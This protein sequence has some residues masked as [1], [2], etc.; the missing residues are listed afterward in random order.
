MLRARSPGRSGSAMWMYD[1]TGGW[2]I[3]KLHKRLEGRRRL[4]ATCRRCRATGWRRRTSTTTPPPTTPGSCSPS[5]AP[6]PHTAPSSPTAAGSSAFTKDDDGQV[7]R[8]HRRRRRPAR[9]TSAPRSSSTP[10]AC[11]PTTCARSTRARTP[12]RSAR[13]RASTSPCRGRR[14][15]TTSPSSSRCRRTSAACSSCRGASDA[16]GTFQHTYVGTTDTDYDGPL[17]DPQCT[18][19]DIAYVLGR[20]TPRHHRRSPPTTSPACGPGCARSSS[21]RTSGRTADLSRRHRVDASARPAS[22]A[23]AG[24]KLTTYREMAEDTVDVVLDRLGRKAALPHQAA[25]RCSAPTATSSRPTGTPAAHLAGRFGT[26]AAA[27]SRRSSPPTRRSASRSSPGLPYLRAEAVY[28]VRH[29]MATTLDDVLTRRTRAHLFDRPATLAAAP[30]VAALI[31]RRARLGRRRGRPPGRRRTDALVRR[32]A[33]PTR[34]AADGRS[35]DDGTD[36]AD[37]ADRHRR[38]RWPGARRRAR[39]TVRDRAGRDL[40]GRR[41]RPQ[42]VAE[43]QPRLVAAGAALGAGRRGARARRASSCGPTSTDQVAAVVAAVRRRTASRS[44]PPAGAAGVAGAS[45]PVFG[46][47]VLDLTGLAGI[48]D[49]D[50]V[51]RRRR[52]A[53]PARSGPTSRP[54]C[55]TRHGLTVGH[56]PQSFDI[57]TVGGWVACRGAGQ[58]STRY[59]KIEDLVVGLE[60]VLADG[61]VVRTGGAPAAAVGPDLDPAVPRLRGHARRHHPGLAARPSRAAGRAARRPTRSTRSPTASRPAGRPAPRRHAGRAAPVRRRRVGRAATAATARAACCSCSTRATRR[62]STATMA[63]VDECAAAV[64]APAGRRRSSTAGSTTATTPR[65]CRALT[66]KG[67]VVDTMEIA[68]PWSR[69]AGAVRRRARAR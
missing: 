53:A 8:R 34:T 18:A 66:R 13:P 62:S 54:S 30:A 12:T 63:V 55:S 6:P 52:G 38:A 51:V 35:R 39:P 15:A 47:V 60:V 24:G 41:R 40:P 49:V 50:A 45:V 67:F 2:R 46:G 29:E 42:D 9:S 1:L 7:D 59:G 61:T 25:A 26:L 32:R 69:L 11:G 5:P 17:D 68:A 64:G 36:P 28:A 4:R 44:P 16:D 33:R 31:G 3:G 56:F 58:Y 57:A 37:R 10:P 19:D 27:T 21:R 22:S 43:A 65:R 23:I 14:C 48:V 20:S